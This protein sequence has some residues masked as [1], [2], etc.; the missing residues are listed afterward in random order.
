[1]GGCFNRRA[2]EFM[3]LDTRSSWEIDC[4]GITNLPSALNCV[5][6]LL[7]TVPFETV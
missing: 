1:M 5:D 6:S 4:P 2:I 7:E 3:S